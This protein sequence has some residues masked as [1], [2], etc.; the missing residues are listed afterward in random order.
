MLCMNGADIVRAKGRSMGRQQLIS[1]SQKDPTGIAVS[2][3]IIS[4]PL[5]C[6]RLKSP[7]L[8]VESFVWYE[9]SH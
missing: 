6:R 1:A 8:I 9:L 4:D 5:T 3:E 7:T 2:L